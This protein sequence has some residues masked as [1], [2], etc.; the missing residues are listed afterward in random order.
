MN[1]ELPTWEVKLVGGGA[2]GE[3]GDY[4]DAY[5]ELT[6]GKLS[7]FTIDDDQSDETEEK[8]FFA[9]VD[10]LNA[11]RARFWVDESWMLELSHYKQY[12]DE[13]KA[14]LAA[15]DK[16]IKR[17]KKVASMAFV[18]FRNKPIPLSEEG[19]QQAWKSFCERNNLFE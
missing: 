18:E 14:E 3:T 9:L 16:E 12:A 15:K 10:A 13:M 7:I 11:T 4:D 19:W 6:D 1:K 17:L 2:I 5:W 8:Q